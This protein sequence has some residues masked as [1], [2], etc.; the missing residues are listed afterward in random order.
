MY[1]FKFI[2]LI[3]V[4]FVVACS[5]SPKPVDGEGGEFAKNAIIIKYSSTKELNMYDNQPHVIP[6]IVYQFN[7]VNSFNAL[8]KD[9][10]GIIKLLE[11]KKFDKSVMSVNKIFVSP[12]EAK[13]VFLDRAT[14]TTWVCMVCGYYSMQPSESTLEYKI[15]EYNAWKFYTSKANQKILTINL[16]F[17]KS[18]I[19]KREE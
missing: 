2:F 11:A 8:K 14:R 12:G 18:S 9:K 10:A 6:L 19:E 17:D 5:S 16:Y 3:L 7:N 15:P 4:L 1:Y 13:E